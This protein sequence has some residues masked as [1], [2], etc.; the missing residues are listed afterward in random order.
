MV[1]ALLCISWWHL[2]PFLGFS[3]KHALKIHGGFASLYEH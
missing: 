3:F 1:H 2:N